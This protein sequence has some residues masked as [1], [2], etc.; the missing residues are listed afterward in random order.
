MRHMDIN[1]YTILFHKYKTIYN[2]NKKKCV[3]VRIYTLHSFLKLTSNNVNIWYRMDQIFKKSLE[4][5]QSRDRA[6]VVGVETEVE[7]AGTLNQETMVS[8]PSPR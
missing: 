7:T 1:I 3:T 2:I 6:A 4:L 5:P 8:R